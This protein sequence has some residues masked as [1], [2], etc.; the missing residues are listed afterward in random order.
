MADDPCEA[1][2]SCVD[3]SGPRNYYRARYY[4]PKVGRFISEDPI[5]FNG[6]MN[7]YAYVEDNPVNFVDP[8]GLLPF[9][10]NLRT[11]KQKAVAFAAAIPKGA[12]DKYKHCLVSCQLDSDPECGPEVTGFIG[13]GKEIRDLASQLPLPASIR[14]TPPGTPDWGDIKA[15]IQGV[16]CGGNVVSNPGTNCVT[17]CMK[18]Y[19]P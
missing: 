5:G 9:P 14:P 12:N 17:E 2:F 19:K 7:F 3:P 10:W 8:D 15:D 13:L 16:Q 11:C 4:D 6:G 1:A 18:I